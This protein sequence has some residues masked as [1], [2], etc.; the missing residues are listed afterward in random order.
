MKHIKILIAVIFIISF[1]FLPP[2]FAH[3]QLEGQKVPDFVTSTLDRKTFALRDWLQG[4]DNEVLILAFFATW[5][6]L[7]EEDLKFLQRLQ[8]QYADEG[9]RV[10]CVFTGRLSKI[11]AAKKYMEEM[12]IELPVLLD[13]KRAVSKRCK[14]TGIPSIYAIDREG[15]LRSRCVGFSEGAK[16]KLEKNLQSLLVGGVR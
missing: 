11:K 3:I 5:C 10:V 13:T 16:I 6:E 1:S 14:V 12:E 8:D 4:P 9:L 2:A 15:F 7:R